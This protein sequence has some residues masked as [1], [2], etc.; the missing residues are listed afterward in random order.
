MRKF[1]AMIL[2]LVL[3]MV[4]IRPV[5]AATAGKWDLDA[6]RSHAQKTGQ[7]MIQKGEMTDFGDWL[8][9]VSGIIRFR[10]G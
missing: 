10:F 8:R 6:G 1:A 5:S 3:M 9:S 4:F 2:A 7:Q